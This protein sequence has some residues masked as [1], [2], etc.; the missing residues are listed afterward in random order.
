MHEL[1]IIGRILLGGYFI[2]SGF[3][4]LFKLSM[5][6][7]Y[8]KSKHIPA[9]TLAVAVSGLI[10]LIGGLGILFHFHMTIGILLLEIFLI[11]TTLVMH[12]FWNVKDP[13]AR[14]NEMINFNKNIA[15]IGAL[16]MII[17]K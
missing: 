6:A 1:F 15:L 9:P 11:I 3:G 10:L 14:M 4:H 12:Q 7:G 13:A 5:L 2:Y 17:A 8:A 16:L